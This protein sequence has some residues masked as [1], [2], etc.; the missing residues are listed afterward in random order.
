MT[1]NCI[2]S[3]SHS[4]ALV[5][6]YDVNCNIGGHTIQTYYLFII[7]W[8]TRISQRSQLL[9]QTTLHRGGAAAARGTHNPEDVG[10]KPIPGILLFVCFT[11]ALSQNACDFKPATQ[12]SPEW[13]RGSA[14]GS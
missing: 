9:Q 11:E 13:R 7:R 2:K 12:L 8:F 10:S 3:G 6:L 1:L 14:R 5:L 4:P